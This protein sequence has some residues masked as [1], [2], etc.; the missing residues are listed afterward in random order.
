MYFAQDRDHVPFVLPPA[1]SD[2]FQN[3][4]SETNLET[5]FQRCEG[6]EDFCEIA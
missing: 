2:A 1:N 4:K 3:K 5:S 6:T